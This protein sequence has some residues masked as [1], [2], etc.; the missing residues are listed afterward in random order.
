MKHFILISVLLGW[1]FSGAQASQQADGFYDNAKGSPLIPLIQSAKKQIDIEIYEMTDANVFKALKAA[2]DRGVKLRIVQDGTPYRSSC[3]LFEPPST[4]D[5]QSCARAKSFLKD[6]KE[7]GAK[8]VPYNKK[9]LCGSGSQL[10]GGCFEHGK[11]IIVDEKTAMLSSGNFNPTNLCDLPQNPSV[12]NRDYSYVL[13][14]PN[15]VKA[16]EKIFSL[17]MIGNA[18]DVRT[19]LS[20][21]GVDRQLTVSPFSKAPLLKF[22]AS[23]K[24]SILFQN[25]Y[26]E[27]KDLSK[28]LADA[29]QKGVKVTTVVSSLC[30]FG[31]PAPK[32]VERAK[33]I[34]S[35]MDEAG[36]KTRFFTDRIKVNGKPGY[37]HAKAIV[38]DDQYAWVGSVNGSTKALTENRE[39]GIFFSTP[40]SV[41]ALATI[42]RGDFNS[43]GSETLEQSAVC[44]KDFGTLTQSS[45]G[46]RY[47]F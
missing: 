45:R 12:C 47:G 34:Y 5:G 13:R 26:I 9:A 40:S 32:D 11:M 8:Y 25:Q 29:A 44:A 7:S 15:S 24:K 28:A 18:Y 41:S 4:S 30:A 33:E 20:Q 42:I 43:Q 39:F 10:T 3:K 38:V 35:G 6:V 19:V 17:D 2:M 31:T 37:L 21:A 46:F 14:D 36:A 27:D 1:G 16:L 23:A 22:I